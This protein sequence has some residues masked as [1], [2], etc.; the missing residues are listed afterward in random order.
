M[1]T[2]DDVM[3]HL[4]ALRLEYTILLEQQERLIEVLKPFAFDWQ[5]K[6]VPVVGW[7]RYYNAHLALLDI[8]D[9]DKYLKEAKDARS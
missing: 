9:G 2:V 3:Y 6:Q 8:M 1:L 7:E 4:N 5:N